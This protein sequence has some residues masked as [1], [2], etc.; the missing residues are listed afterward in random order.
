L[1]GGEG[2]LPGGDGNLPGGNL[3]GGEGNLPAPVE[4][5]PIEPTTPPGGTTTGGGGGTTTGG[6][7]GTSTGSGGTSTGSGGT[8]GTRAPTTGGLSAIGRPAI[9]DLTPQLTKSSAFKFANTPTYSSNLIP[10][11][12][13]APFDY[14]SQIFN[15]ATGGSTS[16]A[17]TIADLKPQLT[18]R[19]EFSFAQN[20]NY[21][22]PLTN[23]PVP[24]QFD[25]TQQILNAAQGGL[26]QGYAMGDQVGKV[27][28][29]QVLSPQ[30]V[31]G[32]RVPPFF[33]GPQMAQAYRPQQY[34]QG[35]DVQEH[36][37]EFF[38]E[39]GLN[40]LDNTYVKGD[41]DGTSDSVPAMLANGEFVI[42][43]DVVSK[44]GN[45]S[46]DSGADVLSE[47]LATIRQH[48]QNHD[49]KELPPE[50]K[51]ALAYLLDAKR[52]VG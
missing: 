9:K 4:P 25:Y 26:I 45:G 39:G 46:N 43:A 21:E 32:R 10:M 29:V 17:K 20:P 22:T 37:P 3:P 34:A 16:S 38:S 5:A 30:I 48:A 7:G 47:F 51:G 49:P 24:A 15:A 23:I 6:G 13:P 36:N 19:R 1:P 50:S 31:R 40:S 12:T 41:G 42:P 18:E 14:T 44:L 52:K 33:Q 28:G 11:T 27:E 8:G 35:G 2:N